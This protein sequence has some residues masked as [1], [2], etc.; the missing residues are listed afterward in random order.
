MALYIPPDGDAPQLIPGRDDPHRFDVRRFNAHQ[1]RTHQ[2]GSP[3]ASFVA[4]ES[5]W[6][7]DR[8]QRPRLIDLFHITNQS[9]IGPIL[10][11]SS[12]HCGLRGPA[13]LPGYKPRFWGFG[14]ADDD[15]GTYAAH[16]LAQAHAATRHHRG[17]GWSDSDRIVLHM[18][19]DVGN[20]LVTS[21]RKRQSGASWED[22]AEVDFDSL[23]I[24]TPYSGE[25]QTCVVFWDPAQLIEIHSCYY[26]EDTVEGAQLLRDRPTKNDMP[27]YSLSVARNYAV[28]LRALAQQYMRAEWLQQHS[29]RRA[30][31]D[32][33]VQEHSFRSEDASAAITQSAFFAP[34]PA[35]PASELREFITDEWLQQHSGFH[36]ALAALMQEH[37]RQR[38]A[39]AAI[40]ESGFFA[41][42]RAD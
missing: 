9:A 2:A 5:E 23:Q 38:D 41:R 8:L 30:A 35:R 34:A 6:R 39:K 7:A 15:R 36:A 13:L 3:D 33:L 12:Q 26:M 32:A 17:P 28:G 37:F 10:D 42:K 16:S 14:F 31:R 19:I 40:K 24:S 18:S 11:I 21:D 27:G 25:L 29:D 4:D 20:L 1:Q 22:L